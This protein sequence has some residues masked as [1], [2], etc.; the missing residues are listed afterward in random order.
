MYVHGNQFRKFIKNALVYCTQIYIYNLVII[1][2]KYRRKDEK[3]S[4]YTLNKI[5]WINCVI[6]KLKQ[7]NF[8]KNVH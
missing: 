7:R 3:K 2:K 5:H 1:K 6:P 4:I 8:N